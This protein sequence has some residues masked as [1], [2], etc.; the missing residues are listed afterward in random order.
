MLMPASSSADIRAVASVSADIPRSR[1]I[2]V[3]AGLRDRTLLALVIAAG[4]FVRL[5]GG[6]GHPT[7]RLYPDEYI[8]AALAR[9][10]AHGELLI[11]G[12]RARFPAILEPLVTAPFWLPDDPALAYG[13]TKAL[14]ALVMPLAAI[15]VWLIARRL[16]LGR[17]ERLACAALAVALPGAI[18]AGYVTADAV[19]VPLALGAIAA[20]MRALDR[21]T[22]R[23]EL[24]FLALAGLATLA[25]VQYV[26]IP[27]AYLLAA[28]GGS[29]LRPRRLVHRHP[30][31]TG[32]A[33][34][35]LV[36]LVAAGP[37]AILGYY[38]GVLQLDVGLDVARWALTDLS[39]SAY[40]CGWVIVPAAIAGWGLSLVRPRSA[41]E[42]TLAVFIG[43][44]G[45]LIL[46]EAALYAANGAERY[47]ERYLLAVL[48]LALPY[49]LVG[50]RRGGRSVA[51]VSGGTGLLLFLLAARVPLAG[52]TAGFGK[53]DSPFLQAVAQLEGWLGVGAAG[54]VVGV[55]AGL[56]A[57]VA[58]VGHRI[59]RWD[60]VAASSA[61][62]V[63]LIATVGAFAFDRAASERALLALGDRPSWVD[64]SADG[65]VDLLLL[66]RAD[67]GET[68]ATL[69]WNARI[70]RLVRFPGAERIDDFAQ[71]QARVAP[72]GRLVLHDGPPT[73]S[74][75]VSETGSRLELTGA[76]V[77]AESGL[78]RLWALDG[79][80]RATMLAV[81]LGSSGRLEPSATITVWRCEM[82][83]VVRLVVSSHDSRQRPMTMH[84]PGASRGLSVGPGARIVR[85]RIPSGHGRWTI[86]IETSSA[87]LEGRRPVAAIVSDVE[88]I[89]GCA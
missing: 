49:A 78:G 34:S 9:S 48:P 8:Y 75:V 44:T 21:P 50:I 70:A 22:P 47:H 39:L 56:L 68:Q 20:G 54:L 55:L 36:L 18:Y 45:G 26:V 60:V 17:W 15:P 28:L 79:T 64:H 25:R 80:P 81:G 41:S 73:R 7:P 2:P 10:L 59:P 72:D 74:F 57:L 65:P 1:A 86:R 66:P 87:H 5:G 24:L 63:G 77:V 31:V 33:G 32:A 88:L 76:H 84:W 83:Q 11:R 16:G 30:V 46:A 51:L 71:E 69:F 58:S 61:L 13:L 40:A 38:D 4:A 82:T 53:Q 23:S 27:A 29:S 35:A 62:V 42:R 3:V 67:R 19:G 43:A 12:E 37:T 52:H 85:L 6:M 14:H 89:R